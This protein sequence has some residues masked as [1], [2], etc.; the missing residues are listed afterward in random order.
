[1]VRSGAKHFLIDG[2]PRALDQAEAFER[3]IA[4][5]ELVLAF[6]CPEEVMR[7]RLLTRG[8][9][10][11]RSDDNADTI[12]KRFVT[13]KSQSLPVIEHYAAL[14]KAAR[15]SAVNSPDEVFDAV[16]AAINDKVGVRKGEIWVEQGAGTGKAGV[17]DAIF[18]LFLLSCC[19]HSFC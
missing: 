9:S 14:G 4:P 19:C 17:T 16:R 5:P 15:I 10:S 8:Q 11:G 7:A 2:F 18:A 12:L 1:M 6:D 13:F 3:I